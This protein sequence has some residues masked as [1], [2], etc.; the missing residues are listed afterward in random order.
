MKIYTKSTY[1]K[2][3]DFIEISEKIKKYLKMIKIPH[4]TTI[5]KFFKR[6]PSNKLK[7]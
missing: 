6:L 5:Q 7:K 4:F 2:I 1:R 3:I